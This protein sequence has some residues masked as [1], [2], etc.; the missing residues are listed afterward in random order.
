G[1]ELAQTYSRLGSRVMVLV[2]GKALA[3][4]D[5]ELAGFVLEQLAEEGI[6]IHQ[7]TTVDS[8]EG[9]LRRVRVDVSVGG[10]KHVVEG[11]HL[12]IAAGRRPSTSDLG[13]E[14]AGIRYDERAIRVG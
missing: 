4:E 12:L 10:E 5:P 3:D 8:V 7:D 11:S 13:L 6:S 2:A 14:V 1:L 9:G